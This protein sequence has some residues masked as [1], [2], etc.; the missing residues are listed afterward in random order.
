MRK[1]VLIVAVSLLLPAY[2]VAADEETT[3]LTLRVLTEQTEKP[4]ADA[5]VVVR[6]LVERK[7]R[8]DKRTSW[9]A[10]TN[11]GGDLVLDRLPYGPVKIQVIARGYQ[12]HG[13]QYQLDKPKQELTIHLKA[14]QGQVSGY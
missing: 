14:P 4:V 7:L 1:A 8:K 10:K 3:R 13:E 9:E 11:R 2:L 5:H 6:F 12:T